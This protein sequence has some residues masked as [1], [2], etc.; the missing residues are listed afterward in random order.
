MLYVYEFL[1]RCQANGET[2][3]HVCLAE[4]IVD[5]F[6]K[7]RHIESDAMTPQQAEA[8]GFPLT[9]IIAGIN[10]AV[11]AERNSAIVGKTK[12]EAERDQARDELLRRDLV[13][14]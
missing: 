14:A 10:T 12:A 8:L 1:W 11:M 6:G 13:S 3:Y 2:A 5:G 9:A 4:E 7:M